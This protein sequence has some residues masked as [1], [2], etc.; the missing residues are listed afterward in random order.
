M[1]FPFLFSVLRLSI[2]K[3]F[4]NFALTHGKLNLHRFTADFAILDVA[5]RAIFRSVDEDR[6]VFVTVRTVE[7]FF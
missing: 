1:G 3:K 6:N 7:K 4:R 5:L 2:R